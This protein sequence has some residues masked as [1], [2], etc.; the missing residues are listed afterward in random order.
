MSRDETKTAV[1]ENVKSVKLMLLT[2]DLIMLKT[3]ELETSCFPLPDIKKLKNFILY[4]FLM[5]KTLYYTPQ[6]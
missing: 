1:E 3:V 4:K 6:I 2:V 5:L